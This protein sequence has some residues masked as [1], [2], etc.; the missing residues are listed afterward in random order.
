MSVT[1]RVVV[2]AVGIWIA[3]IAVAA[4][5]VALR[6]TAQAPQ[7]AR[8]LSAD[9]EAAGLQSIELRATDGTV[10]VVGTDEDRVR[11]STEIS[12]PGRRRRWGGGFPADVAR[13][14]LV[15]ARNGDVFTARVRVP[16]NDPVVERWTVRVP[17]RFKVI[18]DAN[19]GAVTVSDVSGGVRVRANA[20]LGSEPG[21]IRV[22]VPGGRLD[23]SLHVGE[24]HAR[25]SSASRGPVDVESNV[26]D[27]RVILAGRNIVSPRAPGPGHRLRF[28]DSGPDAIKLRVGV[29]TATLDIK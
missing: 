1:R 15:A 19:D 10:E 20:G 23:L 14:E 18:L 16:G 27:A 12:T 17:R 9:V 5:L 2:I 13:A 6:G 29:G 28:S 24:I 21:L 7:E 11:I 8:T 3:G 26:G 22:N 25:T 4:Q